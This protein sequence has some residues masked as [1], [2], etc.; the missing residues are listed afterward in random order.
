[1]TTSIYREAITTIS[2]GDILI[3]DHN[4]KA[5]FTRKMANNSK[6][7]HFLRELSFVP[8]HAVFAEWAPGVVRRVGVVTITN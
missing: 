1:M 5:I 3:E 4:G 8:R 7:I 6:A 2:S